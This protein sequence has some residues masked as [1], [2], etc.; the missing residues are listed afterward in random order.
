MNDRQ[1]LIAGRIL[2]TVNQ[3]NQ[4]ADFESKPISMDRIPEF[5][6][7]PACHRQIHGIVGHQVSYGD[8]S[9]LIIVHDGGPLAP[10]FNW[11]YEQYSLI[12]KMRVSL[13]QIG[14][15]PEQ[16]TSTYSAIYPTTPENLTNEELLR[17]IRDT[18]STMAG[19]AGVVE[20]KAAD[21]ASW[22]ASINMAVVQELRRRMEEGSRLAKV[23]ESLW[24]EYMSR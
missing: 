4:E 17:D 2:A 24:D 19:H 18:L 6:R 10:F 15:Y 5:F 23:V 13:E 1:R 12:E 7:D 9:E 11:D 22:H 16:C 14:C 21:M 20:V 3:I 8:K